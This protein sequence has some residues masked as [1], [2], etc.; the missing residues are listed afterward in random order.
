MYTKFNLNFSLYTNTQIFVRSTCCK[1]LCVYYNQIEQI[2][3]LSFLLY[4]S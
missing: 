2:E 3:F 4:L 1:Y